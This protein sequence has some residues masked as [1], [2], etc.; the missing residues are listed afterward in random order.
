MNRDLVRRLCGDFPHYWSDELRQ[1]PETWVPALID[2]WQQLDD[3][4]LVE[5]SAERMIWVTLRYQIFDASMTVYAATVAP[6]QRW[7]PVHAMALVVALDGFHSQ[8][9]EICENCGSPTAHRHKTRL[10]IGGGDR[11]LCVDCGEKWR[12]KSYGR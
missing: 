9:S 11:M 5:A 1:L 8:V 12:E 3:L 4:H 10:G 7:T 6:I 2:L